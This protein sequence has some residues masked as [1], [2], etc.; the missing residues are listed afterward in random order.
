[1]GFSCQTEAGVTVNQRDERFGKALKCVRGASTTGLCPIR[2]KLVILVLACEA[3]GRRVCGWPVRGK[4]RF[5]EMNNFRQKFLVLSWKAD[6]VT[7]LKIVETV[8]N[9]DSSLQ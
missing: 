8:L 7:V 4:E 6:T 2:G 9:M 1:M 3:G 5:T